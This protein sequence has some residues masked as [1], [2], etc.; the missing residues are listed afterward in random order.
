[1]K[2]A[3]PALGTIQELAETI[4]ECCFD[5]KNELVEHQAQLINYLKVSNILVGLLINFL[6]RKLE[7]K[8][9]HHPD[10]LRSCS[11]CS[12]LYTTG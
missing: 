3:V 2:G 4:L 7:Y 5:V 11:S 10:R 12:S 1:M 6:K 9:V 8:R